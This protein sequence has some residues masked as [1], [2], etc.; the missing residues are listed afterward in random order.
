[1]TCQSHLLYTITSILYIKLI[2]VFE[3][4]KSYASYKASANKAK[5]FS[6]N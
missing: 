2:L 3:K 5:Y 1:M 4:K 6:I